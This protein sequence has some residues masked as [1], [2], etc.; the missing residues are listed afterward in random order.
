MRLAEDGATMPVSAASNKSAGG[1]GE[2]AA[3]DGEERRRGVARQ[4]EMQKRRRD[5]LS[6][7]LAA[8]Q[9]AAHVLRLAEPVGGGARL[10]IVGGH[11]AAA[12]AVGIDRVG[13]DAV[14][15]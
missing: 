3:I 8:E 2:I 7:D 10:D 1:G 15:G 4:R 13:A 9:I 6:G 14:A 11:D 5:I 12:D